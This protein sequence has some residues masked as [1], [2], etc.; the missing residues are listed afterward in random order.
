MKYYIS[1]IIIMTFIVF[2]YAEPSYQWIIQA[3]GYGNETGNDIAVD[4]KGN[5]Y[6]IGYFWD[7]PVTFGNFEVKSRGKSD[8]FITKLDKNGKFLWVIQAGGKGPDKGQGITIDQKGNIYITGFFSG[9]AVFGKETIVSESGRNT[10]IAK[11]NSNG[12]YQWVK[13]LDLEGTHEGK[14]IALDKDGNILILGHIGHPE[15]DNRLF[16]WTISSQYADKY[17]EMFVTKINPEG[18]LLW[19]TRGIKPWGFYRTF[20]ERDNTDIISDNLGNIY[21]FGDFKNLDK[22]KEYDES[23]ISK[24]DKNGSVKW[25]ISMQY[26][27]WQTRSIT[28]MP[29][30]IE[31]HIYARLLRSAEYK[32]V[33][34]D[35]G[36]FYVIGRTRSLSSRNRSASKPSSNEYR[37]E[38]PELDVSFYKVDP[39]G[40]I[41]WSKRLGN[42]KYNAIRGVTLDA[43]NNT[44]ITGYFIDEIFFDDFLLTSK[45]HTDIFIAKLQALTDNKKTG[46]K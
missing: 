13:T 4:N 46:G 16:W 35:S 45:G 26:D 40:D 30:D 31:D 14:S 2:G 43:D 22:S 8:I 38:I 20:Y 33:M 11:L 37:V 18:K 28:D 32:N 9:E 21:V 27:R 1:L 5:V 25:S 15:M 23:I 29:G 24:I 36:N 41:K 44:Y 19:T 7:A 17:R 12:K 6:V 39:E 42:T 34:D 3:G 10:F